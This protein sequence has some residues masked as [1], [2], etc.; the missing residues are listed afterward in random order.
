MRFTLGIMPDIVP[1]V[2][3]FGYTSRH[4]SVTSVIEQTG[5]GPRNI[6]PVEESYNLLQ[7]F[8]SYRRR[9]INKQES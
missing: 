5:Q 4:L 2:K 6:V 7:S 8:S 3:L 9:M 1:L